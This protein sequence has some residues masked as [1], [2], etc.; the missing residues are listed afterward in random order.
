[1]NRNLRNETQRDERNAM[2][3]DIPTG[4]PRTFR[5]PGDGEKIRTLDWNPIDDIA[6]P[7][8]EAWSAED[9]GLT[10]AGAKDGEPST[11]NF[12]A[13]KSF[14]EGRAEHNR[15]LISTGRAPIPA[16]HQ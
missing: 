11:L 14:A 5:S 1:M 3:D 2:R 6:L 15:Y 9:L 7:V 12:Y 16:G 8:D 4:V 13:G 10:G